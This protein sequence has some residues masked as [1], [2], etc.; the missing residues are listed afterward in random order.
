[1]PARGAPPYCDCE[2]SPL[3][4]PGPRVP[5]AGRGELLR[6]RYDDEPSCVGSGPRPGTRPDRTELLTDIGTYDTQPDSVSVSVSVSVAGSVAGSVVGYR[7]DHQQCKIQ[8]NILQG[9]TKYIY[10]RLQIARAVANVEIGGGKDLLVH[11]RNGMD[12]MGGW[13]KIMDSGKIWTRLSLSSHHNMNA[14]VL[15]SKNVQLAA[16]TNSND[17]QNVDGRHSNSAADTERVVR[18]LGDVYFALDRQRGDRYAL[19][20]WSADQK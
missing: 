14:C 15:N 9:T 6:G 1:M 12:G 5:S 20:G 13:S 18:G 8:C 17:L 10:Y 3:L 11:E 16:K 19:V 7:E 4:A 2:S